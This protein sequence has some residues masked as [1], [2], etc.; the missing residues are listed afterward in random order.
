[1]RRGGEE[2]KTRRRRGEEEGK[3]CHSVSV[4]DGG[5]PAVSGVS[6]G[7]TENVKGQYTCPVHLGT[8]LQ[9]RR[10]EYLTIIVRF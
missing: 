7:R 4:S 3:W 8:E 9:F 6:A 10:T 5:A 1:M 2:E